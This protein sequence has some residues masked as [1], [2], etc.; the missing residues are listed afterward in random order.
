MR[1]YRPECEREWEK[2][3][4]MIG[5]LYVKAEEL[6]RLIPPGNKELRRT[7]ERIKRELE[8]LWKDLEAWKPG[9]CFD[10]GEFYSRIRSWGFRLK[11]LEERIRGRRSFMSAA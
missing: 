5:D 2:I 6:E 10:F 7:I 9:E 11:M 8:I 1:E 4:A 3:D